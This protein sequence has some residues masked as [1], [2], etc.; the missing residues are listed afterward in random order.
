MDERSKLPGNLAAPSP[1]HVETKLENYLGMD[2]PVVPAPAP[3]KQERISDRYGGHE[4]MLEKMRRE[5]DQPPHPHESILEKSGW[6]MPPPPSPPHPGLFGKPTPPPPAPPL[7][8]K[9]AGILRDTTPPPTAEPSKA[10]HRLMHKLDDV[11]HKQEE[12]EGTSF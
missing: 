10:D 1:Q 12:A 9:P 7:A 11:L 6:V 8:P 5:H 3:P 4:G 2:T